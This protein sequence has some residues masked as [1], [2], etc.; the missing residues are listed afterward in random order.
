M[1]SLPFSSRIAARV[2][3]RRA[4][5]RACTCRR[6]RRRASASRLLAHHLAD[7]LARRGPCCACRAS[8]GR[9]RT[10]CGGVGP[11]RR[12]IMRS[13]FSRYSASQ[14]GTLSPLASTVLTIE[15]SFVPMMNTTASGLTERHLLGRALVPVA[16]VV[17]PQAARHLVVDDGRHDAGR[18]DLV[19]E[20]GPERAGERVA[21]DPELQRVRRGR[22]V[23]GGASLVARPG[24]RWCRLAN[25]G[26]AR[27]RRSP[28]RGASGSFALTAH[29][30]TSTARAG[31]REHDDRG[32][33][34]PRPA[35]TARDEACAA[36]V[37]VRR[38]TSS[39]GGF[40]VIADPGRW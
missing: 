31:D 17:A 33:R 39:E 30:P 11:T 23:R 5:R 40:R 10:R 7:R 3:R 35:V 6:R 4:S 8:A 28:R 22:G 27:R 38:R 19:A 14:S 26:G 24:R 29:A 15:V 32:D 36:T 20:R 37:R 13:T 9:A 18:A 16:D 25:V 21:A 34:D 12:S 2:A 1:I